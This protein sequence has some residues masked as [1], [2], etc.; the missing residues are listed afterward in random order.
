MTI[1]TLCYWSLSDSME[2]RLACIKVLIYTPDLYI[3]FKL[4]G[5]LANCAE[6]YLSY[7]GIEVPPGL[8]EKDTGIL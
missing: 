3:Y 8:R 4:S 1:L 6:N 2:N 7:L 5:T